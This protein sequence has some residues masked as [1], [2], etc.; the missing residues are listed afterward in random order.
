MY[1]IYFRIRSLHYLFYLISPSRDDSQ[2]Q[3]KR[4]KTWNLRNFKSRHKPF[5]HFGILQKRYYK[6]DTF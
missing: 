1:K 5:G 4:W 3:E 2:P 6:N